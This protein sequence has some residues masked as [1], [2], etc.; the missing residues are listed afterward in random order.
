MNEPR[1][2]QTIRQLEPAHKSM[3]YKI[4]AHYS[5]A[6]IAVACIVVV[7]SAAAPVIML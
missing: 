5:T 2:R 3:A 4:T 7:F 6:Y 1:M